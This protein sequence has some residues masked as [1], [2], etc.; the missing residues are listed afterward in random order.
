RVLELLWYQV[1][2]SVQVDKCVELD[3]IEVEEETTYTSVEP[4][5]LKAIMKGKF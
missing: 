1:R 5:E 2:K 3:I 4:H